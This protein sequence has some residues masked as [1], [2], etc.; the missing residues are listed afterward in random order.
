VTTLLIADDD[1]DFRGAARVL[2]SGMAEIVTEARNGEEAV[3]IARAVRPELVLMDLRMPILDGVE[4][5]RRIK[6]ELPATKVVLITAYEAHA[7]TLGDIGAEALITKRRLHTHLLPAIRSLLAKAKD[8]WNGRERRRAPSDA[9][10]A[11]AKERR[12]KEDPRYDAA[13]GTVPAEIRAFLFEHIQSP[14]EL[15]TLLFL[16]RHHEQSFM[17]SGVSG[18]LR[19]PVESAAEALHWLS[20]Q[21]LIQGPPQSAYRYAP[22]T[23]QL[24]SRIERLDVL[25]DERRLDVIKLMNAN[26]IERVRR[27]RPGSRQD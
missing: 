22:A 8:V 25:Y 18:P 27:S 6:A 1:D 23:P 20:R 17:P 13:T 10:G 24:A 2:V 4:A 21:R 15:E 12:C 26:A 14:V 3:K 16:K 7:Q 9:G 5:T 11:E 19:I